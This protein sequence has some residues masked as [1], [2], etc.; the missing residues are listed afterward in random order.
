MSTTAPA[1]AYEAAAH[2]PRL[3]RSVE[4]MRGALLWL[5]GFAS[6]FVFME[7][8][9]YEIA[10]LLTIVVFAM[11]GLTLRPALMPLVILLVLY[12]LGFSIAVLQVADQPKLVIWVLVSIYLTA[13]A[14]FF[15]CVL[16]TNTQERLTLLCRGLVVAAAI[17]SI[18]SILAYF[19]VL[20]GLSEMFLRFDRARGTFN[21]P[22]VLGA[23]LIF[24]SLLVLQR[25]LSER[26]ASALRAAALLFL[27]TCALLLSFSRAAWGQFAFTSVLLMVL[28]FLTSR[29]SRERTRLIIIAVVGVIAV[30]VFVAGLL[31]IGRVAELFQQRASLEQDY[32]VGHLGR[33]GRYT[34]GALLGLDNPFGIG[35][36]QFAQIFPED[37]HNTYLNTFMSGG[38]LSGLSYLALV[39]ATLIMATRFVFV[40]TPWQRSYLV[41]YCAFVGVQMESAIIDTD[42]WRHYFLLLGLIWGLMIASRPY[43]RAPAPA[44]R[45]DTLRLA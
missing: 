5:T 27:F 30:A 36:M 37:P 41:V 6:A 22:N 28:T 3:S 34:L 12:D 44:S 8:S 24:P 14:I 7:P 29:S 33:F 4:R 20:G 18:V 9:P 23:F 1:F 25:I 19:R 11:T 13:T 39:I 16:N 15:A 32:D 31:S 35:P 40:R 45:P 43:I 17:A 10:A 42:H 26:G 38:W 21:D 2:A